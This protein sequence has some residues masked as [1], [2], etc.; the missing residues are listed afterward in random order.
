M[1]V[2]G[3]YTTAG[4]T[5]PVYAT[6]TNFPAITIDTLSSNQ[7]IIINYF[8]NAG[9][10]SSA[11]KT[12]TPSSLAGCDNIW[13]NPHGDPTWSTHSPLYNFVTVQKSFIWSECHAVSMLEGCENTSSPFQRLNYLTTNGLKCWKTSGAGSVTC[14]PNIT[15][16]HVKV[17][18]SPFTYYHNDDPVAQFMGTIYSATTTGSEP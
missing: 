6:L 1:G 15:E 9:I 10:L 16:T 17:A 11:Y 4:I 7:S 18:S 12:E 13:V 2:Q 8:N 3:I 14:G 5:V